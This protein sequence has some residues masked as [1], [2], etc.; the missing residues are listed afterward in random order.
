MTTLYSTGYVEKRNNGNSFAALF[1]G[2]HIEVFKGARPASPDQ[3]ADPANLLAVITADGAAVGATNGLRFYAQGRYITRNPDQSVW[4]MRV[5][6]GGE[7]TWFRI[8]G[9]SD[10]GGAS[11]TAPRIDG[12]VGQDLAT[13]E[14]AIDQPVL[15]EGDVHS[16]PQWW[17]GTPPL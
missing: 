13:A 3:P 6:A 17:H 15:I 10:A 7:A 8:V 16:V 2:G 9:A 12:D 4:R 11:L 14:M 5:E 1:D